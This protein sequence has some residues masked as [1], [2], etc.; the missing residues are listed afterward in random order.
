MPVIV[1]LQQ[2]DTSTSREYICRELLRVLPGRRLVL[3]AQDGAHDVVL[4]LFFGTRRR[5]YRDRESAGLSA[6]AVAG[7]RTPDILAKLE[8]EDMLGLVL[9]YLPDSERIDSEDP[10]RLAA[11]VRL[12]ARLHGNGVTQADLHLNNFFYAEG[13][14]YAI[15]GDGVRTHHPPLGRRSSIRN[16]ALLLAQLPPA[17]GGCIEMLCAAYGDARGWADNVE[18]ELRRQLNRERR[19]RVS[20]Y[21]KKTQRN[22]TEF[23]V[24]GSWQ[25]KLFALRS[26]D[27]ELISQLLED[28]DRL[29]REG[30]ILK[31]GN[32]A[33]VV[34]HR[35]VSSGSYVIKRY[36][37]KNFWHR[38][39][40]IFKPVARFR[41]AWCNGQRLHLMQIP[42]ARPLA[43]L[44]RRI[45]PLRGVAYLV[46]QDL[47]DQDLL[48][49]V[50]ELGLSEERCNELANL[51]RLLKLIGVSHGDTKGTNFIVHNDRI[52]QIDLDGMRAGLKHL[53]TD[54]DRFLDNWAE[55]ERIRF[56]AAFQRAGLL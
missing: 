7:A 32:S 41:R 16:F 52:H 34:R 3:R 10:Q 47:G 18:V 4:K 5:R 24:T 19:H 6:L 21:L 11:L 20:R 15:D 43:L 44:E 50:D 1:S 17:T 46:F 29:I 33:T 51:F 12:L 45:G 22:C 25:H 39:R 38:L 2:E 8:S 54:R 49:E 53:E 55:P 31:L 26:V 9:R 40:R 13:Q 30:E 48:R 37:V 35:S 14:L 27:D 23:A 42:T 36:N 28:P 56:A